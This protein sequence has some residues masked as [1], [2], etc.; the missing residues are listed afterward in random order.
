M[1]YLDR[2]RS[3][4]EA[5]EVFGHGTAPAKLTKPSSVGSA[6]ADTQTKPSSE[7]ALLTP[8][9]VAARLE[10]LA[11]LEAQPL[12]KRAFVTRFEG[13]ALIVTLALRDIGTCELCIPQERFN[14]RGLADFAALAKLLI[15]HDY[16]CVP[17][18][19]IDS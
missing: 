2:L 5:Q 9:Q 16:S 15:Q 8:Q 4:N 11:R 10:V 17:C 13:A 18:P 6:V 1:S 12:V 14:P 19:L 3:R 7:P